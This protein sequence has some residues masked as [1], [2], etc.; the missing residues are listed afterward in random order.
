MS[1][2]S[3]P[4]RLSAAATP[5]R[6]EKTASPPT[7]EPRKRVLDTGWVP[8]RAAC[9]EREDLTIELFRRNYERSRERRQPPA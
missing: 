7:E 9:P 5:A 1:T 6:G 3:Y 8:F 2:E 4:L